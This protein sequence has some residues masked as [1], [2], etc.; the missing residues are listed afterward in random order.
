[1]VDGAT[2]VYVGVD[3]GG[4]F[5]DLVAVDGSGVVAVGKAPTTPRDPAIGVAASAGG[6]ADRVRDVRAVFHGTTIAL[7]G[8]LER[9][10]APVGLITTAGFRDVLEIMRTNRPEMYDLQQEKP[11]PL[12]PR[13]LRL[14]VAERIAADGSVV[15]A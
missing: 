10:L 3:V 9:R 6:L 12:V 4:T 14:E 15:C 2:A 13:R 1:M 5:T 11:V 7:N 8:L